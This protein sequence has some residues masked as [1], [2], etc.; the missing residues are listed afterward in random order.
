M[1]KILVIDDSGFARKM[2]VNILVSEGHSTIEAKD[3]QVGLALAESQS[4]NLI[5]CDLIMPNVDGFEF[6]KSARKMGVSVPIWIV[7]SDVQ[8]ETKA[9]VLSLGADL[10]LNKP[11]SR[12]TLVALLAQNNIR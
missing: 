1:A 9:E 5:L 6:I 12:E 8:T 7:T 4:P 11:L 10:L 2:L 3:G